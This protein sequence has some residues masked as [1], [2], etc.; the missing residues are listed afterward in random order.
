MLWL[1]A[2]ADPCHFHPTLIQQLKA[3]Y[4]SG[5]SKK[6]PEIRRR[7]LVT[8]AIPHILTQLK[9]EPETWVA[10]SSI[11]MV[12]LAILKSVECNTAD[13]A[14]QQLQS[15]ALKSV[16]EFITNPEWRLPEDQQKS[17]KDAEEKEVKEIAGCEHA[18]L[19]MI[20]K[21]LAQ[22]DKEILANQERVI[23]TFGEV[24]VDTISEECVKQWLKTNRGSFLLVHIFEANSQEV[25]DRI[26]ELVK[27]HV[28]SLKKPTTGCIVLLKKIT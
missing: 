13:T 18:G 5:T 20:F 15:A 9:D 12:T 26:I 24:L 22:H 6:S 21:K 23:K 28:K 10:N 7:E 11:G 1:V 4:T 14:L 25:Q 8:S 17:K 2:P 27:P 19:H 16:C 3:G